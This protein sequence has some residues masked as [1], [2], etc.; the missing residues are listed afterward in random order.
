MSA[1]TNGVTNATTNAK[2]N[3]ITNA[4]TVDTITITCSTNKRLYLQLNNITNFAV[5]ISPSNAVANFASI[6]T[7][8]TIVNISND[9]D[10]EYDTITAKA[11]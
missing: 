1:T 2:N 7:T 5:E 3:V 9:A 10:A 11:T 4:I 6:A 8:A